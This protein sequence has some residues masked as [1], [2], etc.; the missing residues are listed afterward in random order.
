MNKVIISG[1]Y[2]F[3]ILQ[4]FTNNLFNKKYITIKSNGDIELTVFNKDEYKNTEIYKLESDYFTDINILI[5]HIT[6]INYKPLINIIYNMY[7]FI[8]YYIIYPC[9]KTNIYDYSYKFQLEE[10]CNNIIKE[11]IENINTDILE[12]EYVKKILFDS[13]E[14]TKIYEN[15]ETLINESI[16]QYSK[17]I[18]KK[19]I[20]YLKPV[21][22]FIQNHN[23][24][25][26]IINKKYIYSDIYSY[27]DNI[28][29]DIETENNDIETENSD[30]ET[31]N[32]D[33]SD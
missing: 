29:N 23:N 16:N 15:N 10:E 17:N 6:Y 4:D 25:H 9:I 14:F 2:R 28:Y 31:E 32:S 18:I 7:D 12:L 24:I 21:Y 11:I 27:V 30:I 13:C 8:P 3:K 19:N 1:N 22:N 20:R 26:P 5:Y 33:I